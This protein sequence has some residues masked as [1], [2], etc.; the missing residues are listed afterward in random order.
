MVAT[1]AA[2]SH[3]SEQ[4]EP[5]GMEF[6]SRRQVRA[7]G[8]CP[9]AL[10]RLQR[11][12][13][14][15]TLMYESQLPEIN[16][17]RRLDRENVSHWVFEEIVWFHPGPPSSSSITPVFN[18]R[19]RNKPRDMLSIASPPSPEHQH[20]HTLATSTSSANRAAAIALRCSLT[21]FNVL[22]LFSPL[23][24]KRNVR[25]RHRAPPSQHPQP[26]SAEAGGGRLQLRPHSPCIGERYNHDCIGA[27]QG[28]A[29]P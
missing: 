4:D 10:S 15:Q 1:G 28:T 23:G 8:G 3:T 22:L 26:H 11:H 27:S 12:T 18:G 2:P 6:G 17:A 16:Q 7:N 14:S 20:K 5:A 9:G 29:F 21:G 13:R 19:R 25:H 24:P